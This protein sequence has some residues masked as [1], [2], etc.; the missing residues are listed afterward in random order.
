MASVVSI[1][2]LVCGAFYIASEERLSYA[3]SPTSPRNTPPSRN[4]QAWPRPAPT[5]Q[6]DELLRYAQATSPPLTV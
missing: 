5:L 4:S 3:E 2:L 6:F 1:T